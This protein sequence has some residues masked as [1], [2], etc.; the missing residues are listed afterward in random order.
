MV[1][2]G[3]DNIPMFLMGLSF[4]SL[5]GIVSAAACVAV[6]INVPVIDAEVVVVPAASSAG[7]F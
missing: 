2:H 6:V 1:L 5:I 7:T 3:V 4:V